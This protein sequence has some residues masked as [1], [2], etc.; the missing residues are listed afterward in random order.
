MEE[1]LKRCPKCGQEKPATN[2]FFYKDGKSKD[3]FNCWCIQ[4]H[5]D[6]KRNKKPKKDDSQFLEKKKFKTKEIV[7]SFKKPSPGLIDPITL[8]TPE[9]I[10][11][12]LRR[13]TAIEIMD[14][15]RNGFEIQ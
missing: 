12:A 10:V 1:P 2:D 9:E 5:K 8:A 15:I 4:C 7:R 13:G 14:M 11:K 6:F 3:G